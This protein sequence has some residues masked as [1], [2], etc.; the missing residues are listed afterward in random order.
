MTDEEN[1]E[2][3]ETTE[4]DHTVAEEDKQVND[5]DVDTTPAA[6]VAHTS[7]VLGRRNDALPTE[8]PRGTAPAPGTAGTSTS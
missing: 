4:D 5:P 7:N 3:D 2:V 8:A 1:N 6:P